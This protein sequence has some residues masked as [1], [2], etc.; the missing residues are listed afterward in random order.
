MKSQLRVGLLGL[1]LVVAL[2]LA[3]I[4]TFKKSVLRSAPPGS[5][6][7]VPALTLT[8]PVM[9]G[10]DDLFEDVNERAGIRFTNQ[11]CDSRIANILESNGAGGVWLD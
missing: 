11:Y 7:A 8:P 5:T 10:Q 6:A 2:G 1:V 3:A 4:L 9:A